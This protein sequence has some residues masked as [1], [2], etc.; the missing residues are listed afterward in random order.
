MQ[1]VVVREAVQDEALKVGFNALRDLL[2]FQ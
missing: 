2:I 1:S